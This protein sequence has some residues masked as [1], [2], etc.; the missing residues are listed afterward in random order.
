MWPSTHSTV[1]AL[2]I[3]SFR[4]SI[5]PPACAATDASST[6][7]R[8]VTHGSR[9]NA[10]GYSF[11]PQD[12]HP[13][14]PHQLAWR[15]E[16]HV[17]SWSAAPPAPSP[18]RPDQHRAQPSSITPAPE[19]YRMHTSRVGLPP[20]R[21]EVRPGHA[22]RSLR[23][24]QDRSFRHPG[25]DP[26]S[27][28]GSGGSFGGRSRSSP[29]AAGA[30]DQGWTPDQV[31]GDGCGRVMRSHR[32]RMCESSRARGPGRR[33]RAHRSFVSFLFLSP[34]ARP[35]SGTLF[36]AYRARV[37]AG[38]G[39]GASAV[40]APDCA[41]ETEGIPL[42]SVSQGSLNRRRH[43]GKQPPD[44]APFLPP[45]MAAISPGVKLL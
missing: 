9:W 29:A 39:A 34:P 40:R 35:A 28:L 31:R 12:F 44:A 25:L 1:S 2:R 41:R 38:V 15:S 14:P 17:L 19:P 37:R 20:G 8:P 36:R 10:V 21:P 6:A 24:A 18:P 4:R 43:G 42:L 33:K 30:N 5:T 3:T 27:N 11:V 22:P 32:G 7:S 16:C 13:L 26:G 45:H 23:Q